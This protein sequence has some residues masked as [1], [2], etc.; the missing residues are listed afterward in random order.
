MKL[1]ALFSD[2]MVLQ[3][4]QVV[5]V[6]GWDT[7]GAR[8]TVDLAGHQA[9]AVAGDDGKWLANLPSM[10][11]GGPHTMTVSGTSTL[12]V[13]D[14]LV[15]EV[16]LGSGQ[17]NMAWPLGMATTAGE[18]ARGDEL[19]TLRLF[20]VARAAELEVQSDVQ[21]CW[22]RC[23]P[24]S[25]SAFSAV[26]YHFGRELHRRL[27]V[28]VGMINSSWGG[29]IAE[30]WTTR[31]AMTA[32]P[33][34]R[35]IVEN[36][37]RELANP[38]ARSEYD[39][40]SKAWNDKHIPRDPG[41]A[42]FGKG[43]ADAATGTADWPTMKLPQLWQRAG[44]DG[45]GVLWFRREVDVPA[46]WAG[47]DLTLSLGAVDKSDT[48][49]FN[50]AVVGS[51]T[52]E[53][54]PN[55]WCVPRVYTVP[56]KLVKAGRNV[57][58]VRVFSNIWGAGFGGT[59]EQMNLSAPG[60][61][62]EAIGLAGPWQYQV[63]ADFGVVS[64]P[65]APPIPVGKG[66]PNTP[67]ILYNSMIAPLIPYG[68]A[69]V[70]WY[71]GESNAGNAN[72]YRTLFA[73][74]IRCWR[75]AW[76]QGDFPFYFVQLANFTPVREQPGPSDWAALREAQTT[77]LSL[78]NTGMAVII[79]IGETHDIH[80]RNKKDVGERLALA[81]LA[82]T[83]GFE[84]MVH[85]GPM[86]DGCRIEGSSVRVR[87]SHVAG[88]LVA[89]GGGALKGFAIAGADRKF[90]WADATID[91]DCVIVSSANVA[92]PAAVRYA[93]ANNPVCNLYN[94]S[95]LPASPFRTDDWGD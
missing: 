25:L 22:Q 23:S 8:V 36:C 17:S 49:Y 79:D 83:Y 24:G 30:A 86:Y 50:N 29:T 27:G 95:D 81:A 94:A 88:G 9:Q 57:I 85:S 28:P 76:R 56:G 14:V 78:P 15:G 44:H 91:G 41:N 68:L 37:D 38:N 47:R 46:A 43:W 31:Q 84:G 89:R 66:N 58:A 4:N 11:A 6:W 21:G 75:D 12:A 5:P 54:D 42:G 93:W 70:I 63:E 48:T 39:A 40:A 61:G 13:Q 19:T 80:P 32:E 87:F 71:Q 59:E 72:I 18:A 69:G 64:P 82:R 20:T 7:P 2:H 77:A 45:N 10:P 55:S 62:A 33:A 51:L 74:M 3:R 65:P 52:V 60:D 1:A 90:V 34:L 35:P 92:Q 16:W 53:Q 26:A 73:T 67:T